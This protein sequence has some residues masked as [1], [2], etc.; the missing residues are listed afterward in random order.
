MTDGAERHPFL[1]CEFVCSALQ[2][3]LVLTFV[4]HVVCAD[5]GN[6]ADGTDSHPFLTSKLVRSRL[7]SYFPLALLVTIVRS[8]ICTM[9]DG[10]E[11]HA[12]LGGVLICS[13]LRGKDAV[14]LPKLRSGKST[15]WFSV[16]R[17]RSTCGAVKFASL[18]LQG[19]ECNLKCLPNDIALLT[20][21]VFKIKSNCVL[22]NLKQ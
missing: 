12:L 15:F 1:A 9:A 5:V 8:D 4:A 14:A 19:P 20:L 18:S 2:G 17:L 16:R 7:Q 3:Q 6:M 22:N 10:A 21:P 11:G 13:A